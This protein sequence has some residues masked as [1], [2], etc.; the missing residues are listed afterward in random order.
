M[1]FPSKKD[2]FFIIVFWGIILFLVGVYFVG[3]EPDGYQLITYDSLI[4]IIINVL[5]IGFLLWIWFG[6]G[7]LVEDGTIVI[8]SGPFKSTVP[9][10]EIK[11]LRKT[12]SPFSAPALSI[13]RM[14][15]LYG[16]YKVALISPDHE[17]KFVAMLLEVNP[18]I[19]LDEKLR[20]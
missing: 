2:L 3:G 17:E 8:R 12:K 19:E 18:R 7:Y 5:L 13:D 10:D 14:E 1:Y 6:T 20:E 11:K 9:I 4:G 15:I 16:H